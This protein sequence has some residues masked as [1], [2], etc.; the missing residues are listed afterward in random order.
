MVNQS[1]ELLLNQIFL[2]S[3]TWPPQSTSSNVVPNALFQNQSIMSSITRSTPD[4]IETNK[5]T[6]MKTCTQIHKT[7]HMKTCTQIHKC[8]VLLL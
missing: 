7:K 6:H 4:T 5:T 2:K 8:C 3:F 1:N